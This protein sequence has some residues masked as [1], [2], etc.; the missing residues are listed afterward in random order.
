MQNKRYDITQCAL[1][2][3]KSKRRLAKLLNVD[4]DTLVSIQ[5]II[6]YYTFKTNKKG[7]SEKR[8]I[9]A[10][11]S[12][13]KKIQK[14]VLILLQRVIR[15]G[16]LISSEKGKSYIDNGKAH[17]GC[18]YALMVDIKK[19]YDN[20]GRESVYLFFVNKLKTSTDVAEIL[21]DITT[22]DKKIPTGCPT[23][24]IM[25]YY[26]YSDMFYEIAQTATKHTCVFTLYVDDMTFSSAN[27]FDK[28]KLC[29]DID[30]VLRKYGHK[31]KYKKVRYYSSKESKPI[32]GTIVTP[33]NKLDIP[34][35]L[36]NKVYDGFKDIKALAEGIEIDCETTKKIATLCGQI[37]AAKNIDSGRF[38]E[39][40][41]IVKRKW[42]GAICPK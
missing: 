13:L 27:P 38:Q 28:D 41:R 37:Q 35:S 23:S 30:R 2:K 11:N 26:A 6:S 36:Q 14:R 39:I 4:Y 1:Y 33:D 19:F 7:T 16:W 42:K 29:S 10:P 3:C 15:P 18:Q 24:Q 12:E 21:A 32:T 31:P 40:G 8:D 34:N 25:A 20:C 17:L 5:G 9:T 22:L